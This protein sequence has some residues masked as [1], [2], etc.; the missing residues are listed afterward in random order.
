MQRKVTFTLSDTE[1]TIKCINEHLT[2]YETQLDKI[3][4]G[5][6]KYFDLN[7]E[8]LTTIYVYKMI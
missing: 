3:K 6:C 4:R 5:R 7:N 8:L 2:G 1:K